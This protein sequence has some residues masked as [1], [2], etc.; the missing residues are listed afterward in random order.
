MDV[1]RI[2]LSETNRFGGRKVDAAALSLLKESMATVGLLNPIIVTKTVRQDGPTSIDTFQ[3]VAG[4]HRTQAAR[5]LG[6][7]EIDAV[8]VDL[9]TAHAELCEIDE[10]LARAELGDAERATSH[11]RREEIMVGLGLVSSGPGRKN[12]EN[13]SQLAYARQASEALGVS[14][15]T[16][17]KDLA[18]GKKIEPEV[19]AEVSGTSLDKGVVLDELASTPK[20]D[21]RAKL[22]E[23]TLRRAE[24]ERMR[25]EAESANR[26]TDR[27]IAIGDAE[28]FADWLMART[29]LAELPV[30]IAWLEGTKAKDV[31]AA[32]RRLAA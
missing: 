21:Q 2:P 25:K 5:E 29:D 7:T 32:L 19:L 26:N 12:S 4:K 28:Q 31:I 30:I 18:R 17:E 15:R 16:V 9:D 11:R 24:A 8:I 13:S 14:K 1:R 3:I 6:W 23:I 27:V 10:N 20:E 22:A